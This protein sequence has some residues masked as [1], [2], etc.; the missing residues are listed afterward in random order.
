MYLQIELQRVHE[1]LH[2]GSHSE[3]AQ[4]ITFQLPLCGISSG[5]DGTAGWR[6]HLPR[7]ALLQ[8]N[9]GG[10]RSKHEPR[11][12]MGG[13]CAVWCQNTAITEH[14]GDVLS[15]PV[16]YL[17]PLD[18]EQKGEQGVISIDVILEQHQVQRRIH[19]RSGGPPIGTVPRLH[20]A[21]GQ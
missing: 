14:R 21:C 10:H 13:V 1:V 7:P 16:A 8:A 2:F 6:P 15:T 17:N 12:G 9:L 11:W 20:D 18:E 4:Q 3:Q 5:S 19:L